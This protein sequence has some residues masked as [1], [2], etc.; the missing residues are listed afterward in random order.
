MKRIIIYVLMAVLPV[1][2]SCE[3]FFHTEPKNFLHPDNYYVNKASV[4]AGLMGVYQI[5]VSP[6]AYSS[7]TAATIYS[8]NA[9]PILFT[10]SDLEY[11]SGTGQTYYASMFNFTPSE[12]YVISYWGG[13]YVGI[14]RANSFIWYMENADLCTR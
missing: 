1:L 14:S 12:P 7:T 10:T 4:D 13:C 3:D 11:F 9:L 6:F 2:S 5:M 8:G